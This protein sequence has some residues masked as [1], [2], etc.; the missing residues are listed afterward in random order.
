MKG[1]A[2]H[3][4]LIFFIVLTSCITNKEKIICC[5][6]CLTAASQDPSGY[7]ISMKECFRYEVSEKCKQ[8]FDQE[9]KT[10]EECRLRFT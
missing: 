4:F 5:Q 3:L 9:S 10:V 7:D 8:Y 1:I 6:E 2:K